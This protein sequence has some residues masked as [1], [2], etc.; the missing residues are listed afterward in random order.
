MSA[1]PSNRSMVWQ[2][3]TGLLISV[4]SLMRP[5]D[6]SPPSQA[7]EGWTTASPR[8]EVCPEFAYDPTGGRS[9]QGSWIIESDDCEGRIG[10]WQ[11][12]IAVQGG[13]HYAFRI[14]RKT[15]DIATPRRSAMARIVW[16]DDR[17][18]LVPRP[19]PVV[20]FF[21]GGG[22]SLARPEFPPDGATDPAG[23]TELSG[24]YQAPPKATRAVIELHLRWAPNGRIEW[25]DLSF[26]ESAPRPKRIVRLAAVHYRPREG[27]TAAEKREQFAPLI[28]KAAAKQVDLVVLPETLTFYG[29][30]KTYAEAAEPIPGPS[31]DY[32]AGLAK[33]YDLWIVA[34]LLER[35]GP[36]VYNVAVLLS[37]DG[38]V[39]G[40][41]R[42]VCL[43]RGEIMGG[44]T[45]GHEYPVFE[46]P[47][48]KVGM[49]VCYDGFFPEVARE[50]AN[51]GAEIIAW[52]V[53]GCNPL[54]ARAR[55]CENH[56]YLISSTYCDVSQN[57]IVSGV[58]DHRGELLAKAE[59][60]GDIAI[61]EVDLNQTT[62]WSS[63]GDF[64]AE[65]PRHRP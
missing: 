29:S 64:K 22:T 32:F 35:D 55:A 14:Y 59:Q 37:P 65:I 21:R 10:W 54:L 47:F 41:Y 19:G 46:T 7:P 20:D 49:M 56:I 62:Q 45:P 34:G 6:A 48:G 26:E 1:L 3:A 40:K 50:L 58:F 36:L 57:W 31:S 33:Q 2:L 13:H 43:P 5:C 18:Q 23:W 44:V 15:T 25:S 52:P 63:L 39:A 28:A 51:R 12:T 11:R 16:Q 53:W 60:W 30:G 24:V 8:D 38:E 42:K 61:A 4:V 9:G 17:G 27:T